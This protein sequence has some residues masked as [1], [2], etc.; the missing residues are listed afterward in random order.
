MTQPRIGTATLVKACV[1]IQAGCDLANIASITI[2]FSDDIKS[3]QAFEN[4]VLS[5]IADRLEEQEATIKALRAELV[6]LTA[7][8]MS[9]E[10]TIR[11]LRV[12]ICNASAVAMG[13]SDTIEKLKKES[14][15]VIG[16]S[17]VVRVN[18][19]RR[20]KCQD[21]E[22]RLCELITSIR[23]DEISFRCDGGDQWAHL[24]KSQAEALA[25]WL[26]MACRQLPKR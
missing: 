2:H 25:D 24:S 12:E 18:S 21:N 14:G 5:Q 13:H 15:T 3:D 4:F 6:E 19:P 17:K 7:K 10:D 11:H 23:G 22:G 26:L 8:A 16:G 1:A 9:Q 20:V